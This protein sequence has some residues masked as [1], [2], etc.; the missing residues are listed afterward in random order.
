L[1]QR[2]ELKPN[3]PHASAGAAANIAAVKVE[4]SRNDSAR[5]DPDRAPAHAIEVN[6]PRRI[7][8]M[9]QLSQQQNPKKMGSNSKTDQDRY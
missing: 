5:D 9:S 1:T 6:P 2:H 7:A 8:A 3:A 4:R